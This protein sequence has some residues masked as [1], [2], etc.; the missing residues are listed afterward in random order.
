MYIQSNKYYEGS[1][2]MSKNCT[3]NPRRIYHRVNLNCKNLKFELQTQKE[4]KTKHKRKRLKT[5]K[6]VLGPGRPFRPILFLINAQP[7]F[8]PFAPTAGP[9]VPASP[10]TPVATRMWSSPVNA[11]FP[12]CSL[13]P[14]VL[15]LAADAVLRARAVRI[16]IPNQTNSRTPH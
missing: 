6:T 2:S 1:N 15:L 7:N 16:V 5:G 13:G 11:R 12:S 8:C 10:S 9:R 3:L 14:C 4:N